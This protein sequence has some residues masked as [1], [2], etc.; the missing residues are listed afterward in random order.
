MLRHLGAARREESGGVA[1]WRAEL[2]RR[3]VV[4][5]RTGIGLERAAAA[6]RGLDAGER[7]DLFLSTGCAG[8]LDAR[9]APGDLVVADSIGL[10]G[11]NPTPIGP[12]HRAHA[13]AAAE[14]AGLR[15]HAGHVLSSPVLLASAE[16][17]R[18]AAARGAMAV[19]MEGAALARI[20]AERGVPFG[21]VR[22]ILDT[23]ETRLKHSGVFVD[24]VTGT[25]RPLALAR[26]LLRHPG[27]LATLLA[28]KKMMEAAEASLAL[29]FA[30]YLRS[31]PHTPERT[32]LDSPG[33]LL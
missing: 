5:V 8:G 24:P 1:V 10:A 4:V 21:A 6:A 32:V 11:E 29:F 33:T 13:R 25:V 18:E 30:E 19:E 20:A 26:H 2:P 31:T 3:H 16:E 28:M 12:A 22:S 27:N 7:F 14:R 17:K 9:L 23:V 15:H